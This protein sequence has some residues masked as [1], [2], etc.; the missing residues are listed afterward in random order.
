MKLI[1]KILV[2][3][4]TED[5]TF[6]QVTVAS[7]IADKFNT[8]IVLLSVLPQEAHQDK[9]TSLVQK[10]AN[11]ILDGI[12]ESLGEKVKT[13]KIIRFGNKFEQIMEHADNHSVNAIVVNG[14]EGG[15]HSGSKLGL[16]AEKLIR[17]SHKPVWV[18][19]ENATSPKTIVCPVDFSDSSA[20]ALENALKLARAFSADVHVVNVYEPLGEVISSRF[21]THLDEKDAEMK[22]ANSKA[23]DKFLNR[24]TLTDISCSTAVLVG[25]PHDKI[26]EYTKAMNADLLLLGTTGKNYIYRL[27]LGSVS[28]KIIRDFPCSV[29]ATK[30]ESILHLKIEDNISKIEELTKEAI[31]LE[32]TGQNREAIEVYQKCLVINDMHL[33]VISALAK[34]YK[35]EGDE[36]NAILYSEKFSLIVTHTW[37]KHIELELRKH[38]KM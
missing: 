32:Q 29:I 11:Q 25:D 3:I 6:P 22:L 26:I 1:E 24:F 23:F 38:F 13:Q 16:T 5:T 10:C 36:E 21:E 34:L 8:E 2:P 37:D 17:K 15:H 4:S 31:N 27:L 19:D 12:I 35:K 7:N 28:E 14:N 33:P 9:I 30:S 18:V 20:R